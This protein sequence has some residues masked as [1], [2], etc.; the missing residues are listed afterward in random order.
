M[1]DDKPK[2]PATPIA[3]VATAAPAAKPTA[4]AKSGAVAKRPAAKKADLFGDAGLSSVEIDPLPTPRHTRGFAGVASE[5]LGLVLMPM[6]LALLAVLRPLVDSG[7]GAVIAMF[8][9]VACAAVV[10]ALAG[11]ALVR[12]GLLPGVWVR[13]MLGPLG[14][15]AFTL[16]RALVI[17]TFLGHAAWLAAQS[18]RWGAL[19]AWPQLAPLDAKIPSVGGES[20]VLV[21]LTLI[22]FAVAVARPL[23]K[24]VFVPGALLAVLLAFVPGAASLHLLTAGE[25]LQ[26]LFEPWSIAFMWAVCLFAIALPS[27]RQVRS[28]AVH[29]GG[30]LAATVIPW[31]AAAAV[32]ALATFRGS[33]LSRFAD[34]TEL[35]CARL[36]LPFLIPETLLVAVA[37][38]LP[39]AAPTV[40]A[41]RTSVSEVLPRVAQT[42]R[43]ARFIGHGFLALGVILAL[44]ARSASGAPFM[45]A[46]LL[47]AVLAAAFVVVATADFY[48]VRRGR[49]FLDDL[50]SRTGIYRGVF[51]ISPA[52]VS[53]MLVGAAVEFTLKMHGEL[54]AVAF[55]FS[56]AAWT[57]AQ[58]V[59]GNLERWVRERK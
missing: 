56:L 32:Y 23:T 2:A 38:L 33:P 7:K 43:T 46:Q 11:S 36:P 31:T 28:S 41:V 16:L 35:A 3:K 51:G 59:L 50:Y 29:A 9:G 53:A 30:V 42:S 48:L 26:G 1:S 40:L 58:V 45:T 37:C 34:L 19:C 21:A 15:K 52:G 5:H 12:Y 27:A 4:G 22:L 57:V 39:L 13:P 18:L 54:G 55:M 20:L 44:V 24:W 25:G 14:A 17:A 47:L 49:I 6:S 10:T 8:L